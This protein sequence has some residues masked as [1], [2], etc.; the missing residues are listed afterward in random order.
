M[1]RFQCP[2]CK[3]TLRIPDELAGRNAACP[4]CKHKFCVPQPEKTEAEDGAEERVAA[5]ATSP[6]RPAKSGAARPPVEEEDETPDESVPEQEDQTGEELEEVEEP[7][8]VG[9]ADRRNEEDEE[10]DEPR[11]PARKRKK[12]RRNVQWT[13]P[14][15]TSPLAIG[16]YCALG[17]LGLCF[18]LA[19]A[20]YFI[21]ILAVIPAAVGALV[22]LAGLLLMLGGYL[23][24]LLSAFQDEIIY[25]LACWLVPFFNLYYLITRFDQ[26]R[27]PFL[28][29]LIGFGLVTVGGCLGGLSQGLAAKSPLAPKHNQVTWPAPVGIAAA[30][31]SVLQPYTA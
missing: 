12:K 29:G 18:M 30:D 11:R 19:F 31:V 3:K 1:I 17:V 4:Q 22:M 6:V 16:G 27:K 25:G 28:C 26:V 23:W 8:E 20:S 10:E 7:D 21:P 14:G 15:R 5:A 2:G 9:R 24:F 13:I